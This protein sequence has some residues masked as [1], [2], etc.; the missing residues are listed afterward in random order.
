MKDKGGRS[1]SH[2]EEPGTCERR[3][4][5]EN[6]VRGVSYYSA[7]LGRSQQGQWGIPGRLPVGQKGEGVGA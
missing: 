3:E 5:R 1:R 6:W 7:A 4:G 2:E